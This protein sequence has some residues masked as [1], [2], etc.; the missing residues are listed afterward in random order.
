[1]KLNNILEELN[2]DDKKALL[3]DVD[4]TLA[5][6]MEAHNRA[7]QLA[8]ALNDVPFDMGEHKKWAPYGGNVLMEETVIG[9]G[10]KDK[11]DD[12]VKDKQKL[13]SVCLDK[14][15]I[16][17]EHLVN[18][19]KEKS[20]SHLI[21]IV[22]NGRKASIQQVLEKLGIL[23]H[24]HHI[25]TSDILGNAKPSPEAYNYSMLMLGVEP[26]EVIVFEDSQIGFQSAADAGIDDIVE[27][28]WGDEDNE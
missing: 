9:Q 20:D 21:G 4:D 25:T 27:V 1:M 5:L 14:F 19:I 11:V 3:F 2:I 6:T 16:P 13:L 7:Y 28:S 26:E 22:S 23:Y 12:I 8:F 10:F 24:V 17:N 15:M 18:L